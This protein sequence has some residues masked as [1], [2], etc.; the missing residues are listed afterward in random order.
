LAARVTPVTN[1]LVGI[2]EV[3]V[4]DLSGWAG[5]I[6]TSARAVPALARSEAASLPC[7]AVGEAT[8]EAARAA[9]IAARAGGGTA[10]ALFETL[11]AAPPA[12]PLV[13]LRGRHARGDLAARLTDAG[14]ETAEIVVYDQPLLPLDDATAQRIAAAP[15]VVAPL[16]SPR[17]ARHLREELDRLRIVPD[18]IHPV[19]MSGAVADA[20]GPVSA[21]GSETAAHPSAESMIAAVER[22]VNKASPLER[23]PGPQ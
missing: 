1:P 3:P 15:C 17:T 21:E 12:A 23:N 19:F 16:F 20:W 5:T 9:G 7:F 13:H 11:V 6:L 22:M 2:V 18:A 4:P 10:D 8:A 14:I